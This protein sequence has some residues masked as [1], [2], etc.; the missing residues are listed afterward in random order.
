MKFGNLTLL[1]SVTRSRASTRYDG[2]DLDLGL[3]N[4]AV[5]DLLKIQ[6]MKDLHLTV[7]EGLFKCI[8]TLCLKLIIPYLR[9]LE[10]I[11]IENGYPKIPSLH[12]K[13]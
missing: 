8:Q 1:L 7:I 11:K 3:N 10:D 6:K 2:Y 9:T 4:E 5:N 13:I 12:L